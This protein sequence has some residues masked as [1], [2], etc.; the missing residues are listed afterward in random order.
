MGLADRRWLEHLRRLYDEAQTDG[1]QC[2][3]RDVGIFGHPH[4]LDVAGCE[5]REPYTE[6]GQ[7]SQCFEGLREPMHK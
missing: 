5:G 1:Y 6:H 7:R 2:R 3:S 4:L